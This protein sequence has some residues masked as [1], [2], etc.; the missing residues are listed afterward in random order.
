MPALRSQASNF[1]IFVVTLG[2]HI[3]QPLCG[4]RYVALKHVTEHPHWSSYLFL[5]VTLGTSFSLLSFAMNNISMG[6]AYGVQ[7]SK[8]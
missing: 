4:A 1:R 3:I 6:T 2:L 7:V 8:P 5:I